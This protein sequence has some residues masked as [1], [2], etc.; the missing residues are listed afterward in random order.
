MGRLG[1]NISKYLPIVILDG[2]L[3]TACIYMASD[4]AH[5]KIS[6]FVE[7]ERFDQSVPLS[8]VYLFATNSIFGQAQ[9]PKVDGIQ[10]VL[11]LNCP[12]I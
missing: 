7:L 2:I 4:C 8:F 9:N 3:T 1:H 5:E 12:K 10:K 11:M 6:V